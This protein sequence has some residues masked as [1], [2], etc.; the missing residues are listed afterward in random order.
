MSNLS[1]AALAL[2]RAHGPGPIDWERLAALVR[3]SMTDAEIKLATDAR[4][5]WCCGDP[6]SCRGV[7]CP[8]R[9]VYDA[10]MTTV[11]F[12]LAPRRGEG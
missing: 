7:P 11:G 5:G 9:Q 4:P 6:A 1:P 12:G 3:K 8:L 10:D 2:S